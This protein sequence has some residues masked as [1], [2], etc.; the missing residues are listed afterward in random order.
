MIGSKKDWTNYALKLLNQKRGPELIKLKIMDKFGCPI[1][2]A[3][4]SVADAVKQ[5][6]DLKKKYAV[7]EMGMECGDDGC[8]DGGWGCE[9]DDGLVGDGGNRPPSIKKTIRED[10]DEEVK[11]LNDQSDLIWSKVQLIEANKTIKNLQKRVGFENSIKSTI[12]SCIPTI[13]PTPFKLQKKNEEKTTISVVSQISDL[14][15][16]EIVRR[17]ETEGLSEFNYAIAQKRMKT[18]M[19]KFDDWVDLHRKNYNVEE[20]AVLV[21]GDLIN[22]YLHPEHERTDEFPPPVQAVK[23]G[24]LLSRTIASSAH[25]FPRVTVFFICADNHSRLDH[26]CPSK[27]AGKNSMN[28]IVGNVAKT[29]LES[30]KN[31]TFNIYESIQEVVEVRKR[32]YLILHGH[33]VR[34]GS[35]PYLS[36]QKRIGKE[37]YA[38]MNMP[39]DK[40]FNVMVMGH[41]HAPMK[42]QDLIIGGNLPGSTEYDRGAGRHCESVQ[43]AWC[44]SEKFGEFDFI[45]F[46]LSRDEGL[47]GY[48]K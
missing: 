31:V 14:H 6:K 8:E 34:G 48:E 17:D 21:T 25:K 32:K 15:C 47:A 38:R 29:L 16:G 1:P 30:H 11:A 46:W 3:V 24:E 33:T 20:W 28:Y 19:E 12:Q 23:A 27:L 18:Y 40:K 13:N 10:A 2:S 7:K 36:A 45:E 5:K 26:K 35:N 9:G 43:T 42:C 37:S 44:V 22:N 39:D 41:Y 4:R